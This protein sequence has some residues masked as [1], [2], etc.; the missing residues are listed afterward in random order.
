LLLPL[1]KGLYSGDRFRQWL[2]THL[3]AKFPEFQGARDIEIRFEHIR[4]FNTRLIIFASTR[5]RRSFPFDSKN[6]NYTI[7]F[8]CRCSMAIPYFFFPERIEGYP[9]FDG[10]IQNNYPVTA[11]MRHD[12]DLKDRM[13]F[14]G[15]YLGAK[16]D[17]N[18]GSLNFLELLSIASEAGDQEDL[19]TFIDRTVVIDPRPIKTT[20]FSLSEIEIDFLLAE[21]RA[22][23]L[24]WL[25]YWTDQKP[26]LSDV[27][28]TRALASLLLSKNLDKQFEI[29]QVGYINISDKDVLL[30]SAGIDRK[31]GCPAAM[32]LAAADQNKESTSNLIRPVDPEL[33]ALAAESE[34][35]KGFVLL[36]FGP[37]SLMTINHGAQF[38]STQLMMQHAFRPNQLVPRGAS[39]DLVMFFPRSAASEKGTGVASSLHILGRRVPSSAGEGEL[40]DS[41]IVSACSNLPEA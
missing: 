21:G 35:Q 26:P 18:Y 20:D 38:E 6:S 39:V 2:E 9:V 23:A 8:A 30:L 10:G 13:D 17:V 40:T 32:G 14:V 25:H 24:Q 4:K 3:R 27:S 37:V 15:F 34:R 11:L 33:V 41:D 22:S 7:A 12:P 19:K 29:V 16:N 28:A 31:A 1:R 5:G 36:R